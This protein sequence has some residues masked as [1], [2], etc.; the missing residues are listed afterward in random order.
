MGVW[1]EG[2]THFFACDVCDYQTA[3]EARKNASWDEVRLIPV[4]LKEA[5]WQLTKTR[6]GP[7]EALCPE[8]AQ[9]SGYKM[10]PEGLD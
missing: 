7:W 4:R 2:R 6:G 3:V 9:H 10:G 1:K 8:C 5:G